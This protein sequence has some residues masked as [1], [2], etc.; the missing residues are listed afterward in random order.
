MCRLNAVKPT[1]PADKHCLNLTLLTH[2]IIHTHSHTET[3]MLSRNS[4]IYIGQH[5]KTKAWHMRTDMDLQCAHKQLFMGFLHAHSTVHELK[6]TLT[7]RMKL[8]TTFTTELTH[9]SSFTSLDSV[10]TP[11]LCLKTQHV[12]SLKHVMNIH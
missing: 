11:F 1:I 7:D 6:H 12:F 9:S 3:H 4:C 2:A 8:K 10:Y 5:M